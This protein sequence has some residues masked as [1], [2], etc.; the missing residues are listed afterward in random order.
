MQ[1][2]RLGM[3]FDTLA[4]LVKQNSCSLESF[5]VAGKPVNWDAAVATF[6]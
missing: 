2:N 6:S 1:K 4:A 3:T 5:A